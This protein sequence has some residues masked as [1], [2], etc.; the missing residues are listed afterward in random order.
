MKDLPP[1]GLWI[2]PDGEK[3][4]AVEHLIEIDRHPEIFG[5]SKKDIRG[6]SISALAS[7][8]QVLIRGGWTRYR[9]FAHAY[10]FEVDSLGKRITLI[11]EILS[12]SDAF[13]EEDVIV[14]QARP[15][16]EFSGKVKDVYDRTIGQFLQNPP[17]SHWR[18]T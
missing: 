4:T 2:S 17:K 6:A 11:E 9:H 15:R 10:L 3:F 13:I 1:E 14:S 18:F 8:A 16:K 5:L 7:I 12:D